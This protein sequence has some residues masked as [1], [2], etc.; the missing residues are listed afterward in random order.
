MK[1]RYENTIQDILAFQQF[2]CA[3]SPTMKR[4]IAT[5]RWA[6]TFV[7]FA[8]ALA[9]YSH[10]F[11]V[12]SLGFSVLAAVFLSAIPALGWPGMIRRSMKRQAIKLYA[13]RSNKGL[14]GEHQLE[15][16][17]DGIVERTAYNE[18]RM[19]WGAVERV[20]STPEHTFICLGAGRAYII[21][22]NSI[23]EGDYKAFLAS[24]GQKF[25]PDQKLA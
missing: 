8:A 25:Q 9:Y 18:T 6:M 12:Q 1:I 7:V 21:P 19:A 17:E 15:V 2:Y 14:L 20:E 10:R 3:H 16:A 4:T 23:V 24:L 22:H 5:Q 11:G 13:E